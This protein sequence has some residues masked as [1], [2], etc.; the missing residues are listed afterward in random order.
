MAAIMRSG[1]GMMRP[2]EAQTS[3]LAGNPRLFPAAFSSWLA[4][5][6][7]ARAWESPNEVQ[8]EDRK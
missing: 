1:M 5:Y 7:M 6:E 2:F 4:D 3:F 8:T